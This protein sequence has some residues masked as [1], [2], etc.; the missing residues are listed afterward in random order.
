[1]PSTIIKGKYVLCQ[2]D[3]KD[4]VDLISDGAVFQR[5]GE[6]ITLNCG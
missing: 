2:V 4:M 1:M 3:E 6:M 5:D